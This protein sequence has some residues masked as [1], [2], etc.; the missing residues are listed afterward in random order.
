MTGIETLAEILTLEPIEMNLFRGF[1]PTGG[2]PRI[3]GGQVVAQALTAAYETVPE[4]ICHSLH[5]Y[6]IHPGDPSV[7]I[8]YEVDRARDGASFTTRRVTAIQ[9]GRQIFN[10]AASFH[11]MEHGIEHQSTMPAVQPPNLAPPR[12]LGP[13]SPGL[14]S[15]PAYRPFQIRL[16]RPAEGNTSSGDQAWMRARVGIGDRPRMHQAALAYASDLMLL[17]AAIRPHDIDWGTPGLQF[18]SL[19]H[20]IW[21]HR[22]TDFNQWHLYV[23]DSPSASGARG[24]TRGELFSQDGVLVASV[25]QEGLIRLPSQIRPSSVPSETSTGRT[26]TKRP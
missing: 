25:A 15:Q 17:G 7:P 6:F 9:H 24:F 20:A 19:D 10:L 2:P 11:V 16:V 26:T 4:R 8:L 18:A 5:C 1:S 3:F 12:P 13:P 21:F 23:Q 22:P 14:D